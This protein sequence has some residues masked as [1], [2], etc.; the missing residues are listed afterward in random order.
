MACWGGSDGF[1]HE[2]R[3]VGNDF[4]GYFT[5]KFKNS[6]FFCCYFFVAKADRDRAD[7]N[8]IKNLSTQGLDKNRAGTYSRA[9]TRYAV[10]SQP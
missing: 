3:R 1:V 2:E 7:A 9:D 5:Q 6:A 8:K 10:C 4:D